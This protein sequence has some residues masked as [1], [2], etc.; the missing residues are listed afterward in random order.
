MT[1]ESAITDK[2]RMT[3]NH[4]SFRDDITFCRS[5]MFLGTSFAHHSIRELRNFVNVTVLV[6]ILVNVICNGS[7]S[8]A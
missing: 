8:I 7:G 6:V 5:E 1:G 4:S 2:P 3:L